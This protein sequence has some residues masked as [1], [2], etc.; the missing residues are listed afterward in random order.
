M[1]LPQLIFFLLQLL[2]TSILKRLRRQL[3]SAYRSKLPCFPLNG[4]KGTLRAQE[5]C[6]RRAAG[7]TL[8]Q[9]GE[10]YGVTRER[11]RQ[12]EVRAFEKVQEAVKKGAA[13]ALLP[14]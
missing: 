3:W 9:I 5:M 2:L 14:A 7:E 13:A 4:Q 11:V 6:D 8:D 1:L 12:I 10:A